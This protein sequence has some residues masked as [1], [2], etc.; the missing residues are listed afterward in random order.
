MWV[1]SFVL[2]S[3]DSFSTTNLIDF[4]TFTKGR[5]G[6]VTSGLPFDCAWKKT[7]DLLAIDH[8]R[9]H[10]ESVEV[11]GRNELHMEQR[12]SAD[13]L[14]QGPDFCQLRVRYQWHPDE[15]DL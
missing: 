2:E 11:S 12:P 6:E 7:A 1:C 14:Q 10:R 13:R 5:V 4:N 15:K 9:R 8:L 3:R